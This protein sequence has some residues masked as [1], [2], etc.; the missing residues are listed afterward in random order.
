MNSLDLQVTPRERTPPRN[1]L[2][3]WRW[4][5]TTLLLVMSVAAVWVRVIQVSRQNRELRRRIETMRVLAHELVVEDPE[6]YALLKQ[7]AEWH[8]ENIWRAYLP[9]GKS[10]TMHLATR[11]LGSNDFPFP[12]ASANLAAGEYVIELRRTRQDQ[13]GWRIQVLVNGAELLGLDEKSDWESSPSFGSQ[14]AGLLSAQSP[15]TRPLLLER[16][17]FYSIDTQTGKHSSTEFANGILLWIT[18]DE[19]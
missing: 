11:D 9:P 5:L 14:G 1:S 7:P 19:P 2:R 18:A 16:M 3:P 4:S 17:R 6:Q 15:T 10:Y 8:G 12:A 13:R